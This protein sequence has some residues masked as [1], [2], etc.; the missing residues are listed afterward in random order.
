MST[1]IF[2]SYRREDSADVTGRIYDRLVQR[3]GSDA[4]FKDVDSIPLGTDF[5]KHLESVIGECSVVLVVVGDDWLMNDPKTGERRLDNPKDF[6]RAEVEW[7]IQR[8]VPV[9]PLLVEG[10][11]MPPPESLP[12]GPLR[13]FAY[14]NGTVIGRDPDFHPQV[15]RLIEK[16]EEIF[17]RAPCDDRPGGP[18]QQAGQARPPVAARPEPPPP[19]FLTSH[20]PPAL[21]T[22]AGAGRASP[23]WKMLLLPLGCLAALAAL[24]L[25][26]FFTFKG[27]SPNN[28]NQEALNTQAAPGRRPVPSAN[29]PDA[30]APPKT[31]TYASRDMKFEGEFKEHFVD[32]SFDYPA[33]WRFDP[34]AGTDNSAFMIL[35]RRSTEDDRLVLE[36]FSVTWYASK[37]TLAGDRPR[38]RQLVRELSGEYSERIANYEKVAE[39]ETTVG[40][41]TGYEFRYKAFERDRSTGAVKYWG[42][43]VFLPHPGHRTGAVLAMIVTSY[44]PEFSSTEDV[45]VKGEMPVILNSFRLGP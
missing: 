30:P 26:L 28:Q 39:G 31:S 16:L 21:R 36:N 2:I 10:M 12:E 37:G 29:A 38:F 24:V 22:Q 25:F 13:E 15:S 45:G 35:R 19:P 40:P 20:A 1:K 7:A 9:I 44:S 6:V 4:V 42:R 11:S 41:Y 14:R 8:G 27:A 17:E 32:F 33:S 23:G 18:A 5:R 43:T 34:T 3:F